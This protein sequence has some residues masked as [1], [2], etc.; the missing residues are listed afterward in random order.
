MYTYSVGSDSDR[1]VVI[2]LGTAE[3]PIK[4]L[5]S[6]RGYRS[7]RYNDNNSY[8]DEVDNIEAES[9]E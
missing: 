8:T 1:K 2:A 6:S 5:Y 4:P 3:N 9:E 7:R